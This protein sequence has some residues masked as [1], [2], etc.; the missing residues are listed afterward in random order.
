MSKPL[1]TNRR[2][3]KHR[4]QQ[5]RLVANLHLSECFL[6]LAPGPL[7]SRSGA[8]S[9]DAPSWLNPHHTSAT[10]SVFGNGAQFLN[11]EGRLFI[12]IYNSVEYDSLT[13]YRASP[14]WTTLK[15]TYN[16]SGWFGKRAMEC[17]FAGK[18]ILAGLVSLWNLL[19]QISLLFSRHIEPAGAGPE[20]HS[21]PRSSA[22]GS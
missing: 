11:P 19:R 4:H 12:P 5:V 22:P 14:G 6:H 21:V 20:T 18:D 9:G 15:R 3:A 13:R 1:T 16:R 8:A 7:L 17:W 10:W 2:V